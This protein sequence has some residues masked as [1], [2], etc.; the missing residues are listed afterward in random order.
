MPEGQDLDLHGEPGT[1][2]TVD[3]GEEGA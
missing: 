3:K 2:Q 1:D